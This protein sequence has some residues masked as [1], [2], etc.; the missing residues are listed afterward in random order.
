MKKTP[1]IP[2]VTGIPEPVAKLLGPIKENV[3][4]MTGQRAPKL[5][6]LGP[7]ST[8]LDVINKLNDSIDRL[9]GEK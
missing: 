6:K 7:T 4:F 9:Q 8:L 5:A 3:E 1:A 2:A